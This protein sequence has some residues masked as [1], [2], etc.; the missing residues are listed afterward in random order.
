VP[1]RLQKRG[2]REIDRPVEQLNEIRARLPRFGHEH[3]EVALTIA[4]DG[5]PIS[6]VQSLIGPRLDEGS[7]WAMQSSSADAHNCPK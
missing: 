6:A 1:Q 5:E 3:P 4:T 7:D 2:H